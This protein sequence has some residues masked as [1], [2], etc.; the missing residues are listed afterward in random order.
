[1]L[2]VDKCRLFPRIRRAFGQIRNTT[3]TLWSIQLRLS[4]TASRTCGPHLQSV[5]HGAATNQYLSMQQALESVCCA[6]N[7][8]SFISQQGGHKPLVKH[9][10]IVQPERHACSILAHNDP[11]HFSHQLHILDPAATACHVAGPLLRCST[12]IDSR[13]LKIPNL[14]PD[15]TLIQ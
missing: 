4:E 5:Q 15:S 6:P 3:C 14:V 10:K 12:G 9:V 7:S 8:N 2:T 13:N 1:M 11:P